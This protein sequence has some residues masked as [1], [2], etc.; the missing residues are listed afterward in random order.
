MSCLC[1]NVQ[2]FRNPDTST[3][4]R[5]VLRK[6]YLGLVFLSK[7][8]FVGNRANDFKFY[9]SFPNGFVVDSVERNGGLLLLQDSWDVSIRSYSRG[10][11]DSIIT[12]EFSTQWHFIG[13]YRSPYTK[14][15]KFS[16]DLLRKLH[17]LYLPWVCGKDFNEILSFSEK[18]DGNDR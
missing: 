8:K 18:L 6:A 15:C 2:D 5:K 10:L 17:S 9:I 14:N 13:F 12:S 11:I 7:T 16:S 4:L 3:A 1:W